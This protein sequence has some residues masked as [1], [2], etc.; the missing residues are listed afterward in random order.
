MSDPTQT[1]PDKYA[2][3][4]ENE[5]VRVLEY[6]DTPGARTSPHRHP[7]SVMYTLSS[8]ERR[9]IHGARETDVQMPAGRVAWLAAQEHA[10]E[11]VG[12]TDTHVLFI[13]L[14]EAPPHATPGAAPE[15]GPT[16]TA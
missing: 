11:N 2:V 6:H 1:D 5:R 9:L 15:L 16:D 7:D 12:A 10:G 4:F 13:E 8:F 14:K 3:I